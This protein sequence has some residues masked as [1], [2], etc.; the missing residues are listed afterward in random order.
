M[1]E[2]GANGVIVSM[3][4][5]IGGWSLYAK[6]GKLKHCYN[7]FGIENYFAEGKQA[8]PAGKHQVRMEFTYDGGGLAKG[9][10]VSLYVDGQ[11]DGEG[12]V[13]MT[14]P[15]LFGTDTCIWVRSFSGI[16]ARPLTPCSAMP[17]PPPS[18]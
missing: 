17:M 2:S 14:V 12:R 6:D 7:F 5:G 8:I 18:P 13:D 4:A 3:G 11:K 15:M 9:G 1:P 10:S 16:P